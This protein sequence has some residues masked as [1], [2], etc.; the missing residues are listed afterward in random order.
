[1]PLQRHEDAE[2]RG[3]RVCPGKDAFDGF[4]QFRCAQHGR[5]VLALG[6]RADQGLGRAIGKDD[7]P[8]RIEQ[9]QR[10]VEMLHHLARGFGDCAGVRSG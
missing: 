8:G 4:Q 1:M 2:G 6:I 9:Q 7:A 10:I 5:D 3:F